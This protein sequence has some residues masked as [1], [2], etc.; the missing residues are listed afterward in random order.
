MGKLDYLKR[1]TVSEI[2]AD[3]LAA[4]K[5]QAKEQMTKDLIDLDRE[6]TRIVGSD[7]E[8]RKLDRYQPQNSEVNLPLASLLQKQTGASVSN[9]SGTPSILLKKKKKIVLKSL[10]TKK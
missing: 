3:N 2:E 9:N 7:L 4:I 10:L 1:H 5:S 8:G 6:M